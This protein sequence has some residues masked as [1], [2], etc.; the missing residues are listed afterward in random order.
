MNWALIVIRVTLDGVRYSIRTKLHC[1]PIAVIPTKVGTQFKRL[2]RI[3]ARLKQARPMNK[4]LMVTRVT[5]LRLAV[6][7]RRHHRSITATIR[8]RNTQH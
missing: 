4:P 2:D 3:R 1:P 7:S 5:E 6:R 8:S